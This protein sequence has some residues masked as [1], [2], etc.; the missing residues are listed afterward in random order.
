[1][2]TITRERLLRWTF[3]AFLFSIPLGTKKFLASF[4]TPF[5]NVYT[6]EYTAAFLFGSD[7][8]LLLVLALLLFYAPLPLRGVLRREDRGPAT[9]LAFLIGFA[10]FSLFTAS[11]LSFGA[12]ALLRF[13]GALAAGALAWWCVRSGTVAFRHSAGALGASAV[14]QAAI[15]VLQFSRQGSVGLW[16]L[17][18]TAALGPETPG[19]AGIIVDGLS[20]LRAYGTLP[21]ANILAGFLIL[22][23]LALAYLFLSEE[24]SSV[25]VVVAGGL[26]M[27][28]AG[29]V[30]TFSRSGWIVG[31]G[32]LGALFLFTLWSKVS[33]RRIAALFLIVL[34]SLALLLGALRFAVFP[35]AHLSADDAPVRDRWTM[36]EM[37]L[38]LVAS[39]PWGVGL[40]N[41][42]F[43]SYD[44]RLFHKFGLTARGQ[45][46]PVHNLYLLMAAEIGIGGLIAFLALLL[47]LVR[48][49]TWRGNLARGVGGIALLSLL[50]FGL[51]DHFLW[52]LQAGRLMLW[53]V[54]GILLGLGASPRRSMDRIS[55]S[56]GGDAGSIPAEGTR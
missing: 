42:L 2:M 40:G 22:G 16:W 7:L 37:G 32:A 18:E 8:L 36:N 9:P 47:A 27:V 56:E 19:I 11:Y 44:Q 1:M 48:R 46:Q 14:F 4:A 21:H 29:L 45:W 6:S 51:A 28:L 54:L 26:V 52:D 24:R 53:S 30:L 15:A 39:E 41:Q 38:A 20:F 55:P 49:G 23:V 31:I 3:L 43:Y 25:R 33:P 13:L 10:L 34:F 50:I 5:S 12:Y 35:R 17:G